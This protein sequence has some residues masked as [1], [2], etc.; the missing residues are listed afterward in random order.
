M[1]FSWLVFHSCYVDR[2]LTCF[3][4]RMKQFA[5]N[6][7]LCNQAKLPLRVLFREL[8]VLTISKELKESEV[9]GP[10]PARALL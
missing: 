6:V 8:N 2:W 7:I 1:T 9:Y 10:F 3:L 4:H 5:A